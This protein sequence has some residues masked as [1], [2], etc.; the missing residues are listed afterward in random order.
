MLSSAII[1]T[2]VLAVALKQDYP[3]PHCMITATA[4]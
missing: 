3:I 1:I 2:Y 4:T